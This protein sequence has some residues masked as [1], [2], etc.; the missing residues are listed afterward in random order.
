MLFVVVVVVAVAGMVVLVVVVVVKYSGRRSLSRLWLLC[1]QSCC[2][3]DVDVC[4]LHVVCRHGGFTV[5]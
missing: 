4:V 5:Q 3:V 1:R 2:V